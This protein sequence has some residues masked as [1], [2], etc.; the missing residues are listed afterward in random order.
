[1]VD[2]PDALLKVPAPAIRLDATGAFR[3]LSVNPPNGGRTM[4]IEQ[5]LEQLEKRNKRLTVALTMTV[6]VMAPEL[7]SA[8]LVGRFIRRLGWREN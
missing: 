3:I 2:T 5:R 6:V 1:M 8:A 4:T 7:V